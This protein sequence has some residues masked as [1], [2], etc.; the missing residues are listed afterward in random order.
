MSPI[1]QYDIDQLMQEWRINGFVVFENLVS[2][3][4]IDRI[5]EA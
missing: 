1:K 5:R 2:L 3:E 4:K